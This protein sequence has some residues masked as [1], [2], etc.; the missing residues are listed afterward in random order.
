MRLKLKRNHNFD[1]HKGFAS[2]YGSFTK[3][4]TL[5]L[6]CGE[7]AE[8]PPGIPNISLPQG[9]WLQGDNTAEDDM[10]LLEQQQQQQDQ[11][12]LIN[13]EKVVL[14]VKC[15]MVKPGKIIKGSLVLYMQKIVFKKVRE[16]VTVTGTED[17]DDTD[18]GQA[19]YADKV[20]STTEIREIQRRRF[21]LVRTA[22]E[23]FFTDKTNC[24]LNFE[25]PRLMST[26]YSK[27]VNTLKPPNLAFANTYTPAEVL[28]KSSLTQRWQRR[29]VSNFDYI[30]ALNTIAGRTYNDLRQYPVFPWIIA[31]YTS[32]K[33][34][35]NNPATFRD[36]SKPMGA[37]NPKRL[38]SFKERYENFL[39]DTPPF[40]YATHYSSADIVFFFL[41]RTEPFTS[42]FL[43]LQ[44]KFDL[45][46]RMFNS[47]AGTWDSC[48]TSPYD[49]KE[50]IPEFF[51]F[52]DFLR[53]SNGFDLGTRQCGRA[54]GD[55][56]LPPWAHGSPEEF[57]RINREA[58]ES[59]YVSAH[60]HEW[61]DLIFG[62][63][64]RGQAAVEANNGK[65]THIYTSTCSYKHKQQQKKKCF[66]FIHL[67]CS[68]L[69][70][71][72]F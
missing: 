55:V 24:F 15:E 64:Q 71:I 27:I 51:Y 17:Q 29:E 35:F 16:D 11:L 9:S 3:R 48:N 5:V 2:N 39:D 1:A 12:A 52:P 63:K 13:P 28:R 21:L 23:V 6:S 20:W 42:Y 8:Q 44:K 22:F 38:Q 54:L 4:D 58:L 66:F 30:M 61:I 57:V 34:D 10:D 40:M 26:V 62:Y 18:G 47:I 60:L 45:A 72:F 37:L 43:D 31:D 59:E 14:E 25:T 36:L 65:Y 53:N 7:G 41:I 56:D 50:L 49:V 70:H 33:L 67:L 32:E 46:D 68:S 19:K 69:K